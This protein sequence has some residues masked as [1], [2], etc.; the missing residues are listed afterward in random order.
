M[1]T[2]TYFI[3]KLFGVHSTLCN[4]IELYVYMLIIGKITEESPNN[5]NIIASHVRIG[6]QI[7]LSQS[8]KMSA[9]LN[10]VNVMVGKNM[11]I[12]H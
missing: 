5:I 11:N 9:H 6:N 3:I 7:N 4:M 1:M 2:F 8:M 12:I 10:V